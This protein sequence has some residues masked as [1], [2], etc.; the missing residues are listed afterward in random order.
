MEKV[1][2]VVPMIEFDCPH[3]KSYE[4]LMGDAVDVEHLEANDEYPSETHLY[5]R[6][7][8]CGGKVELVMG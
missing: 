7:P 6:C 3:C 1:L 2:K 5:V 4:H 8:A